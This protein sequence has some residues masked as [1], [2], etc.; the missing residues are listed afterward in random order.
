M[1]AAVFYVFYSGVSANVSVLSWL[2]VGLICVEGIALMIGKGDC[3]LHVYAQRTTGKKVLNDTYLPQ[4]V[5]F[6]GYKKILTV[7]FL[8]GLIFMLINN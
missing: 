5:F 2:A 6:S 7:I 8:I 1:L 3:P 4:W